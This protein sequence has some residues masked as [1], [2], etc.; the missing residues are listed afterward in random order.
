MEERRTQMA[1]ARLDMKL[2]HVIKEKAEKAS[3]LLGMRSLTEYVVRLMDRDAT[4]VI[5]QHESIVVSNDVFDRFMAACEKAKEPN[6]ALR[7]AVAF[8][9]EQGIK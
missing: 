2:D 7:D 4:K 5:A 8:T 1:T 9:R 3:A 6:Q